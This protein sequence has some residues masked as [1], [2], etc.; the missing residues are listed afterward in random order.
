MAL[1]EHPRVIYQKN[2][3]AE[4]ICQVR[5]PAVSALESQRPT[6]FWNRIRDQFP[7]METKES[8]IDFPLPVPPQVAAILPKMKVTSSPLRTTSGR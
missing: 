7:A 3:L 8:L 1:P 2:P 5:Y 6:E 4:V